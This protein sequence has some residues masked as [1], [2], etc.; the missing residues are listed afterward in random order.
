MVGG[1]SC[2]N[3]IPGWW[4]GGRAVLMSFLDGGGGA[5]LMSFLDG[6]GSCINVI[7][8]WGELY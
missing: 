4:G 1:A 3:V 6:G 5:V 7:P 2:I 8:G